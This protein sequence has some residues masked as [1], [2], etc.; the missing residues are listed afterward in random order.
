MGATYTTTYPIAGEVIAASFVP[1]CV[2]CEKHDLL[3]I[4]MPYGLMNAGDYVCP[5]CL[6]PIDEAIT[7]KKKKK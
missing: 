6:R 1:Q 7:E 3:C 4:V 2:L 5:E